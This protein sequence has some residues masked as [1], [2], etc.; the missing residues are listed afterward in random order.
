MY[1]NIF[2]WDGVGL[3]RNVGFV[4]VQLLLLLFIVFVTDQD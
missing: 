3:A 1:F 4:A 2:A